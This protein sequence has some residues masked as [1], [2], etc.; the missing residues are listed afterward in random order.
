MTWLFPLY[1]AGG[2][3]IAAPILLH[4][5]RQPPKDRVLFGS[6]MFL[7]ESERQPTKRRRLEHW[8][9]LLARCLILLLLATMFARPFWRGAETVGGEEGSVTV[10]LVDRSASMQRGKLWA[11]AV[12]GAV[13]ALRK[14]G[15]TD[16]VAVAVFDQSVERVWDFDQQEASAVRSAL[17]RESLTKRGAGWGGSNLGGA[18]VTALDWLNQQSGRGDRK[19]ILISDMQEGAAVADLEKVA[20]P[21]EVI[22]SL[23]PVGLKPEEAGN[24]AIHLVASDSAK[25]EGSGEMEENLQKEAA[26]RVRVSSSRDNV[27]TTFELG[28]EGGSGQSIVQGYL[29]PGASRVL[30]LPADA[31][32]L[33]KGGTLRLKG[34]AHDF[35]NRV[36]LAETTPREVRVRVVADPAM[37]DSA[38]SPL[39]YLQRVLQ[40]TASIQPKLERIPAGTWPDAKGAALLVAAGGGEPLLGPALAGWQSW[41]K[42]GG[43]AIYV[44]PNAQ[45]VGALNALTPGVTWDLKE[46]DRQNSGDYA[47]LAEM[48]TSHP[49]LRPFADSRLRDFTKIRFWKHRVLRADGPGVAVLAKFDSG[50]PALLAVKCGEGT[51]LVLASGW[52]P[53]DSQLALST[54]FVPLWFGWLEAAGFAHEAMA[55]FEVGDAFPINGNAEVAIL[56]PEGRTIAVAAGS[57]YVPDRPGLYQISGSGETQTLAV[58]TPALESRTSPMPEQRLADLGVKLRADAASIPENNGGGQRLDG[59]A[60]ESQQRLWWW[61]L[62]GIL[63]FA[64]AETWL[65]S[66]K[67]RD[68][69][70]RGQ[71]S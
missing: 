58:Q 11:D 59:L 51:L 9:L 52:H 71:E 28:W 63:A 10:V 5:R 26:L 2:L 32:G 47:M 6:L 50:D 66:L 48:D 13:E 42:A 44:V 41:L 67:R 17:V 53:A 27:A 15:P 55:T 16:R 19:V 70:F 40:G 37:K 57:V 54:K 12:D 20:W 29:P 3:A 30:K 7:A 33:A 22:T 64:A 49:L 35:D 34:D 56:H 43:L 65:A 45:S 31:L 18:L 46:A 60:T 38:A 4:L 8:L 14:A 24:F 68:Q 1:L 69:P 62:I 25:E 61:T 36:Y 21:D 23:I 39:Y